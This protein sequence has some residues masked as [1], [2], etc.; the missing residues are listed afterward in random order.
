MIDERTDI[1]SLGIL[2]FELYHR[3][4]PISDKKDRELLDIYDREFWWL[5]SFNNKINT[6]ISITQINIL[7]DMIDLMSVLLRKCSDERA[8]FSDIKSHIFFESID[9]N[10]V[11][12]KFYHWPKFILQDK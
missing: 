9:W 8:S 12:K 10:L 7:F 5:K 3:D 4:V 6:K 2:L 11:P 1:W